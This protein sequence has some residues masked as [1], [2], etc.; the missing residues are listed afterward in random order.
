TLAL[1]D[2]L[3][4]DSSGSGWD[5]G[6]KICAFTAGAY[7]VSAI[8]TSHLVDCFAQASDFSNFAYEVQMSIIK[9][10]VGGMVFRADSANNTYYS[11]FVAQNGYYS[12]YTCGKTCKSLV[13][14]FSP[15]INQGL[16]KTNLLAVVAMGTT[17]TL[18]VNHKQLASV[19]DSTYNLGQI[20]LI[21]GPG[22]NTTDP[23]EVVYNNLKVWSL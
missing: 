4:N 13:S 1:Y 12:L 16:N 18:Y 14:K 9:G 11:F 19:N 5:K 23:T 6:S 2:P 22:P 7:H 3:R 21:A 10:D 15:S 20:G 17:I 8:G